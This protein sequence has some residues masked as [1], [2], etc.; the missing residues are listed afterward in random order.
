MLEKGPLGRKNWG[1]VLFQIEQLGKVS[2]S[3]GL[4]E[5]KVGTTWGS[6]DNKCK[7]LKWKGH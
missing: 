4:K 1:L 2:L 3:R 6:G 5:V 7:G